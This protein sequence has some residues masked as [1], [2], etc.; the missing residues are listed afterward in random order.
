M[1]ELNEAEKLNRRFDDLLK[2]ILKHDYTFE[3]ATD[4][5]SMYIELE[6]VFEWRSRYGYTFNIHSNDHEIDGKRHFH[7]D[8]KEA[9]VFLKMD[10]DGNILESNGRKNIDKKIHK[11]LKKFLKL[12]DIARRVNLMWETKNLETNV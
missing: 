1:N 9:K 6:Q 4:P 12:P 10:F 7:F 11:I 2:P 8:N 5:N 3:Q